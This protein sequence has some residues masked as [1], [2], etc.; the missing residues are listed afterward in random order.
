MAEQRYFDVILA[1]FWR[2]VGVILTYL[3]LILMVIWLILALFRVIS[4]TRG[5]GDVY[6]KEKTL[7]DGL[8]I[9][10]HDYLGPA[11]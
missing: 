10:Q 4:K 3:G 1:L 11:Q 8:N 6:F 9:F 2:Y 5:R 7:H